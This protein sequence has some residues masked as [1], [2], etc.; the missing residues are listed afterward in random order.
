MLFPRKDNNTPTVEGIFKL[1]STTA[2]IFLALIGDQMWHIWHIIVF[3]EKCKFPA[4]RTL[5][6]NSVLYFLRMRKPT[7]FFFCTSD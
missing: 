2:G 4:K 1:R 6:E 5:K 7:I 3:F